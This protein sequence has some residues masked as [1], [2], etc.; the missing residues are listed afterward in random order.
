MEVVSSHVLGERERLLFSA[1]EI[2][3]VGA[4]DRARARASRSALCC[5][6]ERVS[7]ATMAAFSLAAVMRV[8]FFGCCGGVAVTGVSAR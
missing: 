6:G 8:R 5:D 2:L 3:S 1:V 7:V 4:S